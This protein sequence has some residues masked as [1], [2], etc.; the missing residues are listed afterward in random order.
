MSDPQQARLF[1][2][3]EAYEHGLDVRDFVPSPGLQCV[4]CEFYYQCSRWNGKE[5]ACL[6]GV[7]IN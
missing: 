2:L 6:I 7:A 3:I 1:R 4:N 5:A